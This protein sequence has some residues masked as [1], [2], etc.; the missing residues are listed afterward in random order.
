M[1]SPCS[2]IGSPAQ[3]GGCA[4]ELGVCEEQPQALTCGELQLEAKKAAEAED[5]A[6]Q[7]RGYGTRHIEHYFASNFQRMFVQNVIS[8]L[9][10]VS[11]FCSGL[12]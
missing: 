6:V 8:Y 2:G 9:S 7:L 4:R 3:S 1:L 5:V 10:H 12:K 11:L